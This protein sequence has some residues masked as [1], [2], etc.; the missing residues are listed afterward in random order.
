MNPE[1]LARQLLERARSLKEQAEAVKREGERI[2]TIACILQN[3]A[4]NSKRQSQSPQV[5]LEGLEKAIALICKDR[6]RK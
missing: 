5:R 2:E 6:K 1:Q 4:L 3:Y